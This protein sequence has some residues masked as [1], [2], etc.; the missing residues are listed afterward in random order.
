MKGTLLATAPTVAGIT[1]MINKF[2]YSTQYMV[3]PE[4]LAIE[5]P[6]KIPGGVQVVKRGNRYRFEMVPLPGEK[7]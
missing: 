3:N 1:E 7:L 4:T 6:S 5:H 2:Y